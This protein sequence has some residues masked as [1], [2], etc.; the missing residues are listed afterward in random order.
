MPGVPV[1]IGP[2]TGGLHNSAGT[3]GGIKDEELFDVVN[4]EIDT[5]DS[6]VN[7]PPIQVGVTVSVSDPSQFKILGTY[8]PDN[9]NIYLVCQFNATVRLMNAAT[10]VFTAAVANVTAG[11]IAQYENLLYVIP[12]P[13]STSSGGYFSATALTTT[14][15]TTVI[16]VPQGGAA[17]VYKERLFVGAGLGALTNTSRV[18]YSA[19]ADGNSWPGINNFDVAPGSGEG[20]LTAMLVI[21]SDLILF[22]EH[23]T[24]KYGYA[25][26]PA[27]AEVVLLD[28]FVGVPTPACMTPYK[29]NMAYVLHDNSVYEFYNSSYTRISE[30][31]LMDQTTD[32]DLAVG[33]EYGITVFKERLFVRYYSRLYVLGLVLQ[34]W[35]QWQTTHK[36]SQLWGIPGSSPLGTE[37]A[38]GASVSVALPGRVFFIRD[39]RINNL[40]TESFN[41]SI[42]TKL[43]D[44]YSPSMYQYVQTFMGGPTKYKR[45]FMGGLQ[46]A[47]SSDTTL[48]TLVPNQGASPTWD[49]WKANFTWDQLKANAVEWTNN[50]T[51]KTTETVGPSKGTYER[52]LIKCFRKMRFRQIQFKFFGPVVKNNVANDAVR[53]YDL[54]VYLLTAEVV[55]KS[56]S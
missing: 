47:T 19:V 39:D 54:T 14:A 40:D 42:T 9:G 33:A 13:G 17:A 21:G 44:F 29:N 52:K 32:S 48:Q 35:T 18:Y 53:V 10:G 56:V 43:H 28:A 1:T 31:I 34:K 11:A 36:F 5:D 23:A 16:G 6:W 4:L 7:R 15:F 3:G 8:T 27:K 25:S 26:D 50:G 20:K 24:Y 37:I 46:I 41:W 30:G 45:M 2:W 49:Y 51:A 12:A 55:E 22:K 38:F